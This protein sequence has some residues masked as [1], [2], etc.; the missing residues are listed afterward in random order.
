MYLQIDPVLPV[1]LALL[2][3]VVLYATLRESGPKS[4]WIT[5]FLIA[6]CVCANPGKGQHLSSIRRQV[7]TDAIHGLTRQGFENRL[8]YH[9]FHLAS[10]TEVDGRVLSVG[11]LG[12]VIVVELRHLSPRRP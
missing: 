5:V 1:L 11:I 9:D 7:S 2:G 10:V 6:A 8:D 3:V 4:W 12:Q